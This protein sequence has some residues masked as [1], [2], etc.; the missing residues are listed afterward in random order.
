M[1]WTQFLDYGYPALMSGIIAYL[2]Q[3]WYSH[4]FD[5]KLKSYEA[6]L[7]LLK[8]KDEIK[9]DVTHREMVNRFSNLFD[10]LA[11]LIKDTSAYSSTMLSI[12]VQ[13]STS[14]SYQ[15]V[16][17]KHNILKTKLIGSCIFLPEYVEK[18][19]NE[20]LKLCSDH[21]GTLF[22]ISLGYMRG[23]I[24]KIE[25]SEEEY[26]LGYSM[27]EIEMYNE[28]IEK[29]NRT[30]NIVYDVLFHTKS[31]SDKMKYLIKRTKFIRNMDI[32]FI[33]NYE[34]KIHDLRDLIKSFLGVN[35]STNFNK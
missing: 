22:S 18:S 1:N 35:N 30:P 6:D 24:E 23:E 11:D 9:F 34:Q 15:A 10:L 13:G 19:I 27:K 16:I 28:A 26:L 3:K 20:I 32:E 29:D 25:I 2:F 31:D 4:K 8:K 14:D 21:V 17:N 7:E 5:K 33:K 12:D